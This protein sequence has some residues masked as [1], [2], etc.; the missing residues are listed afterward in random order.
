MFNAFCMIDT[1]GRGL[2]GLDGLGEAPRD[3]ADIR[4]YRGDCDRDKAQ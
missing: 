1:G 4:L 3:M 2:V